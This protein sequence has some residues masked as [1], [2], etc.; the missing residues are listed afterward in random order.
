MKWADPQIASS[1][2]IKGSVANY[3]V[4]HM[5]KR[6]L[7]QGR[8]TAAAA[9][10]LTFKRFHFDG[11]RQSTRRGEQVKGLI[12]SPCNERLNKASRF[13]AQLSGS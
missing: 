6:T 13:R 10:D 2:G 7:C 3:C 11:R 8:F 5:F 9:A 1:S 4:F 12:C